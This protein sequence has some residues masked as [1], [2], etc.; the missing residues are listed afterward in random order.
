[1][2]LASALMAAQ[3]AEEEDRLQAAAR[4]REAELAALASGAEESLSTP[5]AVSPFSPITPTPA[6]S[7]RPLAAGQTPMTSGAPRTA[8]KHTTVAPSFTLPPSHPLASQCVAASASSPAAAASKQFERGFTSNLRATDPAS[9]AQ[10]LEEA[11]LAYQYG[12]Y[13]NALTVYSYLEGLKVTVPNL[14]LHIG[15]SDTIQPEARRGQSTGAFLHVHSHC[16]SLSFSICLSSPSAVV[17]WLISARRRSP[18]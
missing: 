13:E 2:S 16:S 11:R 17:V 5:G 6:D 8:R 7:P 10:Y 3:S 9:L 12:K 18:R 15:W 14:S 1:M 4:Q